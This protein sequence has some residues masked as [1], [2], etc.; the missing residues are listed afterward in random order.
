MEKEDQPMEIDGFEDCLLGTM[1]RYGLPFPVLCYDL[2]KVINK[3]EPNILKTDMKIIQ[4]ITH[5]FSSEN[6]GDY[7]KEFRHHS[8]WNAIFILVFWGGAILYILFR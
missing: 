6:W 2:P 8:T 4:K 7:K 5:L 3:Y 1:D